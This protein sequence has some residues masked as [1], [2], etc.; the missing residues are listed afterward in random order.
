MIASGSLVLIADLSNYLGEQIKQW[1]SEALKGTW[2]GSSVVCDVWVPARG[3]MEQEKLI[4]ASR[5]PESHSYRQQEK[6]Q[7]YAV[8]ENEIN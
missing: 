4:Q 7:K 3:P 8:F 1:K 2:C 5:L 6:V